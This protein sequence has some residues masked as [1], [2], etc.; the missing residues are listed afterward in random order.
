MSDWKQIENLPYSVSKNGEVRNDR[1]GKNIKPI[2]TCGYY[3]VRLWV[4][5]KVYYRLVHR[6]VATAFIK[7]PYDKKEVNHIDGVKTNNC[8]T[9][10]EWATRSENQTHR[11]NTLQHRGHNPS[12][13]EANEACRKAVICDES[14]ERYKSITE[15]AKKYGKSQSS[16]SRHLLGKRDEFAGK[17]WRYA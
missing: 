15:A 17:H 9:N 5:Y 7:N 16:L 12:T 1:T 2:L 3:Q 4:N 6:L 13:R 10:L 11:Y 14:G 8:V